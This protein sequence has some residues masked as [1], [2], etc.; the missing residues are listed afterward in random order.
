[1][2]NQA[3]EHVLDALVTLGYQIEIADDGRITATNGEYVVTGKAQ[4]G[5]IEWADRSQIFHITEQAYIVSLRKR[6]T[7]SQG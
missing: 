1:M 7:R 5:S 6:V 3:G 4:H 2:T